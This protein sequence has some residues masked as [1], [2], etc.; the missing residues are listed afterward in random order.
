M[1]MNISDI[2]ILK[3]QGVDYRD[4]INGISKGEAIHLMQNIDLSGKSRTL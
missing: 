2:A 3:S 1:T 4:I